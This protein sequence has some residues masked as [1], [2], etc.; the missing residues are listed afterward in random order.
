[1]SIELPTVCVHSV[2]EAFLY[3]MT[4]R[5]PRCGDGPVRESGELT[6]RASEPGGWALN[7]ACAK[8]G[9]AMVS[10]YRVEPMPTHE[11]AASDL[12]NPTGE[13]SHAIDLLGWLTL[14]Q[15]ILTASQSQKDKKVG[16]QLAWEAA[17][18]LDEAMKFYDRDNEMPGEDA[19]FTDDARL[20]F[21]EHP[22][23]FARSKWRQRRMMM[24]DA[25]VATRSKPGR[26]WWQFW[27][28]QES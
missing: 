3:L 16:R 17:Q 15:S 5:C 7:A 19:F 28:P 1:M 26:R 11:S 12:I 21:R 10:H 22:E 13:R 24:P 14:F 25:R 18:C 27:R 20:R 23:K 4:V 8:C 6:R 2:A 9:A